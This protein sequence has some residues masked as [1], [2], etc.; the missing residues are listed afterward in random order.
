MPA[1]PTPPANRARRQYRS[2]NPSA[3]NR[4]GGNGNGNN[5]GQS[6]GR[7]TVAQQRAIYAIS[8]AAGVDINTV[9]PDYNAADVRDL[10][11]RDASRLIDDLKSRQA[12]NGQQQ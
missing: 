11:I 4:N 12:A 1:A 6:N 3:P 10:A 2:P 8:K 5:G 9:L 7:A